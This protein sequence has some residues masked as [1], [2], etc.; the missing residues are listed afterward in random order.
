MVEGL[1]G[2]LQLPTI[3][4]MGNSL[5]LNTSLT[6]LA[7]LGIVGAGALGNVGTII[8]GVGSTFSP[9]S[10]LTELGIQRQS[11]TQTRG[12][13]LNR[14]QRI[15]N[16]VSTS[17]MVGNSSGEDYEASLTA[18]ANAEGD[19]AIE[20][21]KEEEQTKSIN[22]IHEYLLQV[23]DPKVTAITRMLASVSGTQL[24]DVKGW[25]IFED[26][27][28]K[29]YSATTVSIIGKAGANNS[30]PELISSIQKDVASILDLLQK[31]T[32]NVNVTNK[33]E[34][35]NFG[36]FDTTTNTGGNTGGAGV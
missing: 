16:Q 8:S 9:A 27:N 22:D 25:N 20:A 11:E 21:K 26:A 13:G 1:S 17:N 36:L 33:V 12:V 30:S 3:S 7:R 10:M 34:L 19:A 14:S 6:N 4:V 28:S 32:L 23:F 29:Q 5:D 15:T 18:Q 35:A 24:T 2:G 31:D